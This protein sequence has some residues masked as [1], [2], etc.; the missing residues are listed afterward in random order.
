M[1]K[2][3]VTVSGGTVSSSVKDG[4]VKLEKQSPIAS[5]LMQKAAETILEHHRA[6]EC[7]KMLMP[8]KDIIRLIPT[9]D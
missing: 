7:D 2:L 6:E 4:L 8:F 5:Y 3:L 9:E 1:A